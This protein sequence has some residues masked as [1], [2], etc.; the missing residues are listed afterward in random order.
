MPKC[1]RETVTPLVL[2]LRLGTIKEG[3]LLA[4]HSNSVST[5]LYAPLLVYA[6][7]AYVT[8]NDLEQFLSRVSILTRNIDIANLSVCLSV[9]NVPVSDENGLTY[10]HNIFTVR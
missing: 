1:N 6:S 3:V 4:F 2:Y 10:R 5:F 8:V 9:R 7:R